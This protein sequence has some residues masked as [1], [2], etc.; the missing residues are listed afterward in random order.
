[1]N[2]LLNKFFFALFVI[3]VG[4][5]VLVPICV[6]VALA[7]QRYLPKKKKEQRRFD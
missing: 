6:T 4:T 1:M 3:A 5:C 7:T 2:D